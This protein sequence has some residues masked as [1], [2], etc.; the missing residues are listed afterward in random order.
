MMLGVGSD[1][2]EFEHMGAVCWSDVLGFDTEGFAVLHD[3][4]ADETEGDYR[5]FGEGFGEGDRQVGGL[6]TGPLR[7]AEAEVTL[8]SLQNSDHIVR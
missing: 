3:N 1:P 5:C 8:G 6:A 7:P 2:L 4:E